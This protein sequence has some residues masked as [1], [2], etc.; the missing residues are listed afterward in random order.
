MKDGLAKGWLVAVGTSGTS[1]NVTNA[2]GIAK[3]H[4]YNVFAAFELTNGSTKD[5]VLLM[6]NPW[7]ETDYSS[8]WS[9]TDAK[10]TAATKAE[11]EAA[12][13]NIATGKI[14]P[15]VDHNKGY[16]V[17]PV[18]KLINNECFYDYQIVHDRAK[19]GYKDVRYDAEN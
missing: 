13:I 11:I 8:D 12:T 9:K 18:S 7:S 17:T 15:T 16:F 19:E 14:D 2:C 3:A 1:N 4:V 5:K 6:R 10:W